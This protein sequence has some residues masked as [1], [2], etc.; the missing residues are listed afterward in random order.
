MPHD[1]FAFEPRPG[2]PAPLPKGE[3]ILWQ[4]RPSTR[5]LVRDAFGLRWVLFYFAL[6]IAWRAGVG[7]AEAGM[8]GAVAYGLPYAGLALAA[9]VVILG[10][11]WAQARA[12]VYTITTA[13]VL[14]RI[15]AALQITLNL[16]FRQ[17]GAADLDLRRDGTGTIAFTTLGPAKLSY[18]VLWPHL[19][20][21]HVRKTQPAFRCIPDAAAVARLVAEAAEARQAEPVL[22][23]A[24]TLI[25]ATPAPVYPGAAVPAE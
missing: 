1:D 21:W 11:A 15:G 20:P 18:L 8:A 4:G 6:V 23:R 17:I 25:P 7:G 3:R 19:R 24:P 14:L 13:R 10:L 22:M 2:I 12:T 5:A 16:P 9:S